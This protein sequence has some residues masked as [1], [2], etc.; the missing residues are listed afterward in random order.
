MN[1]YYC[2][3]GD[4]FDQQTDYVKTSVATIT[5]EDTG[6]LHDVLSMKQHNCAS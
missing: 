4:R 5:L 6:I 3:V 1:V 2:C